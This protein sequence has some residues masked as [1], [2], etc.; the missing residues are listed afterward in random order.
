MFKNYFKTAWRNLLRNKSLS[1]IN[2]AGLSI[3]LA[4]CMLIFLYTK[5]EVSYDRFHEKKDS[6]FRLTCNIIEKDGKATKYGQAAMVEGPAFKQEV[7]EIKDFVRVK[8]DEF[9]IK[10]GNETFNEKVLFVDDNFFSVF[11]FPLISGNAKSV[12]SELNS[13][14][15]T[16]ETAIKYFGTANAVGKTLELDVNNKFEPFTV[17]GIAKESPQNS[18]IKFKML[19]P[20]KFHEKTDPETGWLWLS[21]PTY[22]VMDPQTNLKAVAAKMQQVY[23]TKAHDEIIDAAKHGDEG[24]KFKWGAQPMLQMHLDTETEGT[25]EAS[26]PVYS[27]ILTGIAVFIL[28]IACINFINLTVAQSLKRSK[29]IGIRKVVGG[30]RGQLIRQFLGES[31]MLCSIAFV[32]AIILA[33]FVLPLFNNLANKNL[34]LSYLLDFKLVA[35]F[36]GLFLLTGIAA[37]FYPALVL[38]GFD[39]VKT[40]YNRTRFSGKNY[41]SK[42][43]VVVQ[44][45]LAT[46]L[47]ITTLFIYAQFDFLTH[48]DLGYND[49]NL[50]EVNVGQGRNKP[51]MDLFKNEFAKQPGV[52]IVAPRMG[53]EWI[54][55]AKAAGKEFDVKYEHIDENYLPALQ[56]PLIAGRNFSKDFPADSTNSVLVN[57]E[58]AREAGWKYP[59]GKTVDFLNGSACKLTVVGIVKDF[60]FESLKEK[61]KAQLFSSSGNLPFGKFYVRINNGNI[62]N[63]LKAIEKTYR[64]LVPNHPFQYDFKDD[65]NYK[66]YE[67]ENKWKQIISSSAILTIFISCI[68]LFGLTML[69][70]QKRT[71]EIGVRKV[72]GANVLQIST[73]VSRN[74]IA[75]VFIAFIIAIPASWFATNKWL[76]NFAYRIDIHWWVF[77]LAAF[78]T[79]II[80]LVTVSFQAIKAAIAN[81]VKSLRTD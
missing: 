24:I 27:Y 59:V 73:L 12:L 8:D 55:R 16:K 50:L 29:E 57:E 25:S 77:A 38:S 6:L 13:I 36:I 74:F 61:I 52:T 20:F 66:N 78:L 64:T 9:I 68:G 47:I 44:F 3:G 58:F 63:T 80:A 34:S 67:A 31:F 43:L 26:S 42:S 2:I 51:L 76:Q 35:S 22:L 37:G 1:F 75:L 53:G 45:A 28:L 69:T 70:I 17:S 65:L 5:D 72:L 40:L 32:L 10:K 81:P 15:L 18:S 33:Q 39:P 19:L 4:C 49:K 30:Q 62:P 46:F 41:L 71:K 11:S 23:D 60:H 14:V 56:I 48:T 79:G 54:T 7:P 21:Y